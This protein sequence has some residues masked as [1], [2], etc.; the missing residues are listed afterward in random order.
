MYS[1]LFNYIFEPIHLIKVNWAELAK[2]WVNHQDEPVNE[3]DKHIK[4]TPE[5]DFSLCQ[6]PP[7]PPPPVFIY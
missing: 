1:K 3:M 2:M 4:S 7:P 6:P 5:Y